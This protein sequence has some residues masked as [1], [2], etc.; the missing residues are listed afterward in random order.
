MTKRCSAKWFLTKERMDALKKD[1][2]RF[3]QQAILHDIYRTNRVQCDLD[4]S[5][6]TKRALLQETID[7]AYRIKKHGFDVTRARLKVPP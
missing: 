3:E 7:D 6:R 5:E 4:I 1:F 2:N